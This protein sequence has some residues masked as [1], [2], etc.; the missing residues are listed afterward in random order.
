[1]FLVLTR[2]L[3]SKLNGV[4]SVVLKGCREEN[5]SDF[6]HKTKNKAKETFFSFLLILLSH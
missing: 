4:A 5:I 1:V 6:S 2:R 3:G